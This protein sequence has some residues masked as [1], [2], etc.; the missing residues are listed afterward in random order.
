MLSLKT[1]I[2]SANLIE[3]N[4]MPTVRKIPGST[5]LWPAAN[6]LLQDSGLL[7]EHLFN[8]AA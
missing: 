8:L 5:N 3:M 2:N 7:I 6:I 1:L 4:Q